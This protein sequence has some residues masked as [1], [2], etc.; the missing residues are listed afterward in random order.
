VVCIDGSEPDYIESAIKHGLM[1]SLARL[2]ATGSHTLAKSVMPSFTNP[3][4]V[5]IITGVSP[6]IH[7]IAGNYFYDRPTGEEVQMSDARFMRADTVIKAFHHAGAKVAV[8]TAKD[9]LL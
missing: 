2:I 7:G 1:P 9:K 6:A 8:V 5:S 4:N 3:N